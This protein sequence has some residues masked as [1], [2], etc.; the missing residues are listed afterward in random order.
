VQISLV[1]VCAHFSPRRRE[2][3]STRQTPVFKRLKPGTRYSSKV[4]CVERK[5][6][7]LSFAKNRIAVIPRFRYSI[8]A[9]PITSI[10]LLPK[11]SN[12]NVGVKNSFGGLGFLLLRLDF[13]GPHQ[14]KIWHAPTRQNRSHFCRKAHLATAA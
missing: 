10:A 1:V 8:A 13:L 6:W 11:K 14:F 3:K 5:T 2:D 7:Q 9:V 12:S 4:R